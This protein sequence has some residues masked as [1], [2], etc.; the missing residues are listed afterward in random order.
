MGSFLAMI[1]AIVG[2]ILLG[3]LGLRL[4]GQ[5]TRGTPTGSNRPVPWPAA[6]AEPGHG[7]MSDAHRELTE[8]RDRLAKARREPTRPAP[9]VTP[10]PEVPRG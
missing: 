6:P 8:A 4:R 3:L 9:P 2:V 5:V 7:P 10:R 1:G